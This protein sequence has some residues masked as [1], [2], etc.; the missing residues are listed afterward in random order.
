MQEQLFQ[1]DAVENKE[2]K[3][4]ARKYRPRVFK[5]VVSQSHIIRIIENSIRN[6]KIHHAYILIGIRGVGK[7]TFAR[8]LAKALN[9]TGNDSNTPVLE[10]CLQC[11]NCIAIEESRHQDVIEID[12]AS[13]TGVS[14]IKEIIEN[15][16]YKPITARYKVYIIDEVHMLSNSAFSALLKTLEEPP[17]HVKFILATTEL[18]KIPLTVVSR[19]QRFDLHRFTISRLASYLE[20]IAK[21]EEYRL[22]EQASRLL[23]KAAQGSARD[24]LSLLDQAMLTSES[25]TIDLKAVT[26]MLGIVSLEYIYNIFNMVVKGDIKTTLKIVRDLYEKGAEPSMILQELIDITYKVSLCKIGDAKDLIVSDYEIDNCNKLAKNL[27]VI[28]LSRFWQM[29]SKALV[30]M[31]SAHNELHTLEMTLIKVVYANL[32]ITPE[33]ILKNLSNSKVNDHQHA[34]EITQTEVKKIHNCETIENLLN[35]LEEKTEMMLYHTIKHELSII[36]FRSGYMKINSTNSSKYNKHELK[37]KLH[38]ITG[39]EWVIENESFEVGLNYGK[40]ESKK[41]KEK[42]EK[43]KNHGLVQE[44][45]KSFSGIEISDIKLA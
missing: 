45:L 27:T 36:E 40:E 10:P 39:I 33:D 2:Y 26:N 19:C 5:D 12:A 8:I 42:K 37:E 14:D 21:K 29:F 16:K 44:V 30:E 15:A 9:C 25:K 34:I 4:L 7:T 3:V 43:I 31:K 28:V 13:N 17:E 41:I 23:A 32:S 20:D 18:Q 24:G 6:N 22:D 1:D 35:I 11:A 38:K